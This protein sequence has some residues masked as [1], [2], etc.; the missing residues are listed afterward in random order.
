MAIWNK[1]HSDLTRERSALN[2]WQEHRLHER[3]EHGRM[4]YDSQR[5]PMRSLGLLDDLC[6]EVGVPR[7]VLPHASLGEHQHQDP[8]QRLVQLADLLVQDKP[9]DTGV[10]LLGA[11][12]TGKTT[13]AAAL[14]RDALWGGLI[15]KMMDWETFTKFHTS[16]IDI[17]R[18]AERYSD[19]E[20]R[21][22]EWQTE[23]WR[24]SAVYEIFVLDDV[25]RSKAPD[26]VYDE[27]HSLVR[28]RLANGVLTVVTT[29]Y[30]VREWEAAVGT[31]CFEFIKRE[32]KAFSFGTKDVVY[33]KGE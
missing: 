20:D 6:L 25:G 10:L 21:A 28:Q 19:Y 13:L 4:L 23:L 29:N 3:D 18:N 11:P 24:M 14:V 16:W 2:A 30:P 17:S 33:D 9:I 5:S 26:F 22:D 15:C 8:A 27:F 1:T 31:S 12:G 32:F 7:Q